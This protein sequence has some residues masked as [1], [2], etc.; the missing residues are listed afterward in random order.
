MVTWQTVYRTVRG[1]HICESCI[2][3]Y[4]WSCAVCDGWNRDGTPCGNGCHD[5]DDDDNIDDDGG[6]TCAA[7]RGSRNDGG[8]NLIENYYYKPVPVFHGNGPLFLGAEIEVSTNRPDWNARVAKGHLGDLGYLKYDSSIDSGFEIVTHPMSYDYAM[9]EF[10]WPMLSDLAD[11]GCAATQDTGMHVHLSRAGFTSE[12]HRYR[13]LK[14]IYRNKPDVI[15][16]ARRYSESWAPFSTAARQNAKYHA[17]YVDY[18]TSRYAAVNV[19]NEST[20]ELRIFASSLEPVEVQAAL[21]LAAASVEYTR[22]LTPY[23]IAHDGGWG[24]PAFRNWVDNRPEYTPLQSE[25][26]KMACA[27]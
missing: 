24:W 2:G 12:V 22:T 21:G 4:Y 15:K 7:C 27:F 1:S 13:W 18:D 26:E 5:D 25:M 9:T 11:G 14:F 20:F 23:A 10:P 17:K 3:P 8:G 19:C 16:V 6:C